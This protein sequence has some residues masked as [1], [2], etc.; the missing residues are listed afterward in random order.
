MSVLLLRLSGPLQ[1][2]GSSSRF[3]RRATQKE[4]TKSGV[5]GMLAAA[6]GRART[7]SIADLLELDFAV[8]VDQP[9]T[10]ISDLQ[11]EHSTAYQERNGI[12]L[13]MPLSHRYYIS[14]AKFVVAVK[15]QD[16]QLITS[17]EGALRSPSGH[18][19]LAGGRALLIIR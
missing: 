6:Q 2:W 17:L 13:Q 10:V 3:N 12:K 4:P 8:R 7:D 9:G 18:F 5:I 16:I 14:D 15:S 1:S 19:F 11:T